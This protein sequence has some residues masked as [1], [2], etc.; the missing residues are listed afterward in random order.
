[1]RTPQQWLT[2]GVVLCMVGLFSTVQAEL[3]TEC[4]GKSFIANVGT[5]KECGAATASGAFTLCKACSAKLKQCEACRAVLKTTGGGAVVPRAI[6]VGEG[7]TGR[8]FEL[9]P[10]QELVVHLKGN[11]TTG[12]TWVLAQA[13]VKVLAGT[14]E[15]EFLAPKPNTRRVGQGGEYIAR[16]TAQATGETPVRFEYRRPWEKDKP[17]EKSF[18]LTV[19]VRADGKTAP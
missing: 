12:Y 4:R 8:S 7:T 19:R 18:A 14:G 2:A 1:M 3:C 11:P 17:A 15:I 5:C 16:L 13:D 6:E 10:G 9:V